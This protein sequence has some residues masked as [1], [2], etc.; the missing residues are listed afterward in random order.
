MTL[1]PATAPRTSR[2]LPPILATHLSTQP[3]KWSLLAAKGD[4]GAQGIQGT[5]GIEGVKGDTGSQGPAGGTMG[6][7][8]AK[9]TVTQNIANGGAAVALT[10]WA[11][12]DFLD[13]T[14]Y[15]ISGKDIVVRDAGLY[16]VKLG[17]G[18]AVGSY[19]A[20][21]NLQGPAGA[22]A[23]FNGMN[24]ATASGEASTTLAVVQLAAGQAV[25]AAGIPGGR[26][27]QLFVPLTITRAGGPQG[28]QGVSGNA[29]E[30]WRIVGAAGQPALQGTWAVFGGG[31]GADGGV[32]F[33]QVPGWHS[34]P[35]WHAHGRGNCDNCLHIAGRLSPGQPLPLDRPQRPD[36]VSARRVRST[37][38]QMARSW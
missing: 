36:S 5:Q 30:A 31:V 20:Y 17:G 4:I 3:T 1:S 11:R 9:Y 6:A 12:A 35:G 24:A 29:P 8:Y 28:P 13:T 27:R 16:E 34:A 2:W 18:G 10:G 19:R 32:R 15:S 37:S 21:M 25:Y 38:T 14:A 23:A 26:G 22:M 7:S 33:S